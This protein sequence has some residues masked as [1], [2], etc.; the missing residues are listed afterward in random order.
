MRREECCVLDKCLTG[1]EQSYPC[2]I[3]SLFQK[4]GETLQLVAVSETRKHKCDGNDQ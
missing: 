2:M 4:E 3:D 1:F